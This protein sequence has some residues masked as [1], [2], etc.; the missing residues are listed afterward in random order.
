MRYNN[1]TLIIEYDHLFFKWPSRGRGNFFA[2]QNNWINLSRNHSLPCKL[3]II[4]Q[5]VYLLNAK[6]CIF[7]INLNGSV[8]NGCVGLFLKSSVPTKVR[9]TQE[10]NLRQH[11][12]CP[13]A[14]SCAKN[15]KEIKYSSRHTQTIYE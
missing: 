1:S 2:G 15:E 8:L 4:H 5:I 12:G 11:F 9:L 6:K 14:S 7:E 3:Y 13:W 10:I